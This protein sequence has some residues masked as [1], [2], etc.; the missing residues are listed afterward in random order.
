MNKMAEVATLLGVELDREFKIKEQEGIYKLQEDG[1]YILD[2]QGEGLKSS[3]LLSDLLC[4]DLEAVL[5]PWKPKLGEGYYTPVLNSP[6]EY[7]YYIWGN[8]QLEL[9]AYD[10]GLVFKTKDEAKEMTGKILDFVKKERG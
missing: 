1:L 6:C 10:R 8:R 9:A 2:C 4:G 3:K 5:L 7:N